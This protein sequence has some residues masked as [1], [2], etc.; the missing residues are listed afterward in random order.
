MWVVTVHVELNQ[1]VGVCPDSMGAN[2]HV[3]SISLLSLGT[4]GEIQIGRHLVQA[5]KEP[6]AC[7]FSVGDENGGRY[8]LDYGTCTGWRYA[9][10]A[11]VYSHVE[12]GHQILRVPRLEGFLS[13]TIVATL[14]NFSPN[15]R[16][17]EGN[18]S[19]VRRLHHVSD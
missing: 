14:G 2:E 1:V 18:P 13:A 9:P 17:Y 12:G 10:V 16:P 5:G 11:K 19:L 8:K 7:P 4:Q 15:Y 3:S 6:Q